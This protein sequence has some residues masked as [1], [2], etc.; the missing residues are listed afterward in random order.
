[1]LMPLYQG[2]LVFGF[3]Q[4][5]GINIDYNSSDLLEVEMKFLAKFMTLDRSKVYYKT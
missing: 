4:F 3:N 2:H 5:L 1:M